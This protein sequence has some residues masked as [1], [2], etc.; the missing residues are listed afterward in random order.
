MPRFSLVYASVIFFLLLFSFSLSFFLFNT[1]TLALCTARGHFERAIAAL[2]CYE[3]PRSSCNS[4]TMKGSH[5][6]C[7]GTEEHRRPDRFYAGVG[8]N[9]RITERTPEFQMGSGQNIRSRCI[10]LS[11]Q[12]EE[13]STKIRFIADITDFDDTDRPAIR[14]PVSG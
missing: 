4:F 10:S 1:P 13:L 12:M 14:T 9:F 2:F 11:F 5:G 6:K 7:S 8:F 3:S